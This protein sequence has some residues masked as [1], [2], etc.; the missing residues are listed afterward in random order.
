M[1]TLKQLKTLILDKHG[2]TLDGNAKPVYFNDGYMV[3]IKQYEHIT[4]VAKLTNKLIKFYINEAR[5][6]GA[7]FGLWLDTDNK[8]YLDISYKID[9]LQS[10]LIVGKYN[11]QRAI[12]DCKNATSIYLK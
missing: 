9:N 7:Y 1:Q 8:L 12:Y 3:S 2:A 4:S 11:E 10:A 6:L 5:R